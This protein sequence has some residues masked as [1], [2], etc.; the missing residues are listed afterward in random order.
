[1]SLEATVRSRRKQILEAAAKHGVT[2]IKLFGSVARGES[3]EGSDVDFLVEM[4]DGRSLM[5]LGELLMDLEDLLGCKV[6]LVEPEG[7]H[8]YIKDRIL[9]EAVSL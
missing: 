6:N 4:E 5:D 9:T 7:L 2:G 3:R 1:M 8:W